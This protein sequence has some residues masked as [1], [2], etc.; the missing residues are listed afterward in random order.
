MELT[1][2]FPPADAL[3]NKLK[4]FDYVEF[5]AKAIQFAATVSAI[6]VGVVSYVWTA[7]Q[8]WWE[9][10]GEAVQVNSIRFAINVVNF[11]SAI[12]ITISK[13]YRWVKLNSNRLIDSL[14]FQF[15]NN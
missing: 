14:F 15:A 2:S 4:Q 6:V 3:I 12:V 5:G 9:D 11:V 13:I 10:N 7:F 8:L 1:N